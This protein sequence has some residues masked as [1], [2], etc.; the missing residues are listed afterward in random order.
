MLRGHCRS[1]VLVVAIAMLATV[2]CSSGGDGSDE[3]T[4]DD[5]LEV[6][7]WWSRPGEA[8]ALAAVI[9]DFQTDHPG[10]EF[11]NAATSGG[12]TDAQE[13]LATRLQSD[14][15][16]D[17]Y[18]AHAGL[19][20]VSDIKAGYLEPIDDL[21][22]SQNWRDTLPQGLLDAISYEGKFYS[23]PINVHRANLLWYNPK[24]LAAAGIAGPPKTWDEYLAQAAT[25]QNQGILPMAVGPM[26]VQK[27]VLETVLLGQLGAQTYTGLW[28]GTVNWKST[29]V[30]N[31]LT[32][33]S[34]VFATSNVTTPSAGWREA[35]DKVVA[36]TAAYT[37]VGDWLYAYLT[38]QNL[39]YQTDFDV[40]VTPGS[41]NVY[42][43]LADAFTLPKNAPHE[44][45]AREWLIECGSVTGQ[46]LFNP[47]K[48]SVPPRTDT[49]QTKYTGYLATALADWTSPSTT[50][51]GSMAQGTVV[52]KELNEELTTILTQFILDSDA[53]AFADSFIAAFEKTT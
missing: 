50:I 42:D 52:S 41:D 28:D 49:D 23:V 12:G 47:L 30:I 48:G 40:T 17:S 20:L 43:F 22:D 38:S 8:E 46:D 14:N 45:V 31:A 35:A 9:S 19:E 29:E 51:V 2:G 15:P 36:G 11:V 4:G 25:L 53:T 44:A 7:S 26:S 3:G 39:S 33:A 5:Q 16:P 27:E 34:K 21:F 1:F 10:I 32:T 37:I 18:Q 13:I 6:F 24:T